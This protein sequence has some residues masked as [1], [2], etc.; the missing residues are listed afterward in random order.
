MHHL[1]EPFFRGNKISIEDG[2]KFA[3]RDAQTLIQSARFE[4]VAIDPVNVDDP[5]AERLIKLHSRLGNLHRVIGGIVQYLDFQLISGILEIATGLDQAI[6]DEL[7][8]E[9]G[10]LQGD[11]RELCKMRLWLSHRVLPVLVVAVNQLIAM[12]AVKG[13]DHHYDEVGN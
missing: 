2:D 10:E 1:H 9:D 7:L 8:V 4:A 5:V 3:G 13:K 12:D 11:G 6:D